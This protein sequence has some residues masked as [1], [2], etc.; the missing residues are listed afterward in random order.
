MKAFPA[1]PLPVRSRSEVPS[2][3]PMKLD[4]RLPQ[5]I[6]LIAL[7]CVIACQSVPPDKK[8]LQHLN[9]QGFGKRY[10]G[11]AE[12]ENYLTLGDSLS[13]ADAFHP[14]LSGTARVEL[15]GTITL[16]EVGAVHVAGLTRSEVEALLTQK[17]QPYFERTDITVNLGATSAKSFWVLG[18]VGRSGPQVFTGDMT[19][20][21]AVLNAGP[22]DGTANLGRVRLVRP[23]PLE[24]TVLVVNINDMLRTGDSTFNVHVRELD[25]I[26]VPPTLL[27][28]IGYFL[29][30]LIS[31][32]TVVINALAQSLLGLVRL[33]RLSAGQAVGGRRGNNNFR[34]F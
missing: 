14:E 17:Y 16:P 32:I 20:F 5:W 18:E 11:N 19:I 30:A 13:F 25:I 1:S 9:T 28:Q 8:I 23:D 34:G 29:Q 33:D 4:L 6:A 27:A 21:E 3:P 15:D 31:P 7:P 26:Y 24:P 2:S 12:E 22:R 10:T